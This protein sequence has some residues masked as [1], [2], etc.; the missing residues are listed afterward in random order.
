MSGV[1]LAETEGAVFVTVWPA[2][3]KRFGNANLAIVWQWV[4]F[5]TAPKSPAAYKRDGERWWSA[6]R[7]E[8]AEETGLRTDQVRRALESLEKDGYLEGVHH[9]LNG[10][11]DRKRSY[12][13]ILANSDMADL[14]DASG[15]NATRANRTDDV[16]RT[17]LPPS[18]PANTQMA[19]L[20]NAS[21][22]NAESIGQ[23]SPMHRASPPDV[24]CSKEVLSTSDVATA[25]LRPDVIELLD[26]LDAALTRNEVSKLPKRN[27][28]NTDAARRLIDIDGRTVQQV[29]RAIDWATGDSFWRANILSMSKLR[30]KYEQLRL[31]AQRDQ[32]SATAAP[33]YAGRE[34]YT[35]P[36]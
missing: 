7:D 3:I 25:P 35:P 33:A 26:Y 20:P 28:T 17:G 22:R 6:N 13:C 19:N 32:P 4:Y 15:E 24:P 21:G 29:K 14:P 1:P 27:R 23:I 5:R 10:P 11:W 31:S 16:E 36:E 30:E 12:R 9:A 18:I 34:E 2:L 8:I